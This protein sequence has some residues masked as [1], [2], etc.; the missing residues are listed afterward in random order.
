MGRSTGSLPDGDDPHFTDSG[1]C[2][3]TDPLADRPSEN[4][5]GDGHADGDVVLIDVRLVR[6]DDPEPIVVLRIEG[7]DERGEIAESDV[8]QDIRR[9]SGFP[10]G[11]EEVL[12]P[13]ALIGIG[14]GRRGTALED[15]MEAQLVCLIQINEG[16]HDGVG[17]LAS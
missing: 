13:A 9:R 14:K 2:E 5:G 3:P 7:R 1:A 10:R 4:S 17:G 6:H 15:G 8:L 16:I 12:Q 11:G